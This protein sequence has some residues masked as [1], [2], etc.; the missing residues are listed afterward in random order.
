MFHRSQKPRKDSS[1]LNTSKDSAAGSSSGNSSRDGINSP[2]KEKHSLNS[3]ERESPA[4]DAHRKAH[5]NQLS[6]IPYIPVTVPPS[7]KGIAS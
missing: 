4:L 3:Q 1:Q 5:P 7:R 2:L 6:R